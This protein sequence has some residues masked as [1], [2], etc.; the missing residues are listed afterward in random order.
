M[1]SGAYMYVCSAEITDNL[2]PRLHLMY[3]RTH[4]L[5][6]LVGAGEDVQTADQKQCQIHRLILRSSMLKSFFAVFGCLWV[7]VADP[8]IWKGACH[9]EECTQ[10]Y[11]PCPHSKGYP[12][13]MVQCVIWLVIKQPRFELHQGFSHRLEKPVIKRRSDKKDLLLSSK[14]PNTCQFQLKGSFKTTCWLQWI[15]KCELAYS[16]QKGFQWKPLKPTWICQWVSTS[17]W[18]RRPSIWLLC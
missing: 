1:Y 12:R 7:S 13:E 18:N 16:S 10:I 6:D 3:S 9:V 15:N 5:S 14:R 11:K 17:Q 8:G 4:C 2:I